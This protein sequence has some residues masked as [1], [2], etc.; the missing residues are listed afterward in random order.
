MHHWMRALLFAPLG[1]SGGFNGSSQCDGDEAPGLLRPS[2]SRSLY[3][4]CVTQTSR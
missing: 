3:S 2:S 4:I 1:F